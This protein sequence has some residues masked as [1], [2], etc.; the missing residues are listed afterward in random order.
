M[1]LSPDTDLHFTLQWRYNERGSVSNHQPHDCLLNRSFRRRSKKTSKLRVTGLCAGS[2][3]VTGEFPAK[4]ASN[5][6][7]VSIWWLHH[8]PVGNVDPAPHASGRWKHLSRCL[9][10]LTAW[11]SPFVTGGEL[12]NGVNWFLT[13]LDLMKAFTG[14]MGPT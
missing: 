9:P 5:A 4:I 12:R 11:L 3:P 7:N 1:A 2:S 10:K 6:G 8:E 13:I 14:V